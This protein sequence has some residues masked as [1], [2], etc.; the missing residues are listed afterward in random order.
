[1]ALAVYGLI[2]YLNR[3]VSEAFRMGEAGSDPA[4]LLG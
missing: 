3:E 2:V 4:T 1:V